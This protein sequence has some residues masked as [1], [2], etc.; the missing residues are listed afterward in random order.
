MHHLNQISENTILG[1][2]VKISAFVN[3]YGCCIGSNTK[4]GSFVEI[5][6]G[7]RVGENCKISSHSFLCEGVAVEN[8]VF[9]GHGVMFSNDLRPR[10]TDSEGIPLESGGWKCRCTLVKKGAS[11]GSGTTIL[12]GVV[13]G[14][15]AMIGAGSVVTRDV[16]P[17]TTV[18]G[19]PAR[20]VMGVL[21]N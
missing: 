20:P 21:Q 6:K 13:I 18:V 2:N 4:I 7:V 17:H 19:N 5:Q 15:Y 11:V 9:I 14:E 12:G 16:M 8:N 3:L 1:E 10:A